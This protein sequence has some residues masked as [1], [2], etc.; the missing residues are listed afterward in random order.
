MINSLFKYLG[1]VSKEEKKKRVSTAIAND[2]Q[3]K[4]LDAD[5]A[6]LQQKYGQLDP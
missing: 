5:I 3:L 2:S 4:K 1:K 6:D